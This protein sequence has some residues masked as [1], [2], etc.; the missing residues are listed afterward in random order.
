MAKQK[1]KN[2]HVQ[3]PFFE[4]TT[5]SDDFHSKSFHRLSDGGPFF[6]VTRAA[7]GPGKRANDAARD[8]YP[9]NQYQAQQSKK[10]YWPVLRDKKEKMGWVFR[11]GRLRWNNAMTH[12][13]PADKV[14]DVYVCPRLWQLPR[15]SKCAAPKF[16][17][18]PLFDSLETQKAPCR[19]NGTP[20]L[21]QRWAHNFGRSD[22][23]VALSKK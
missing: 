10:K 8:F 22:H 20:S 6:F 18:E 4:T 11:M 23:Q 7:A 2:S 16:W 9:P 3:P 19:A 12:P 17:C 15:S 1:Q 21:R 5:T 14:C 13:G